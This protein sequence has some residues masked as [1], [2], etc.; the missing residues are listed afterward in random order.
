MREEWALECQHLGLLN[1]GANHFMNPVCIDL[2][3]RL[4]ANSVQKESARSKAIV[5][6]KPVR[7]K[8]TT[9]KKAWTTFYDLLF[10]MF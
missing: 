5:I 10:S 4:Q 1:R 7:L 8:D 6:N 3:Q 9:K 2:M